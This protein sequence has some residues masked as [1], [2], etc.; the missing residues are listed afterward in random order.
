LFITDLESV[1]ILTWLET[2]TVTIADI[3]AKSSVLVDKIQ[4]I[5]TAAWNWVG[6][7]V[8]VSIHIIP[9]CISWTLTFCI[10]LSV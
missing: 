1:Y 9:A 4:Y 3:I 5:S 10:E 6:H 7:I 8:E 2:E